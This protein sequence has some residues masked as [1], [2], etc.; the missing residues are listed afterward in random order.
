MTVKKRVLYIEDDDDSR[1]LVVKV[2]GSNGYEV[3]AAADGLEG[4]ALAKSERPQLVLM[5]INLPNLDGRII[6]TRLRSLPDLQDVPIV[7]LTANNSPGSR[8]RALAAGCTGFLTKPIDV[9]ELPTQVASFL[10]GQKQT[11]SPGL[12]NT[13]LEKHAQDVV[14]QL[15]AKVRELEAMNERLYRL[16]RLKSD[17]ITLASHEL[18]T[19]L[20]LVS[21]Y[22]Q[23][24]EQQLAQLQTAV[25]SP[26]ASVDKPFHTAQKLNHGVARLAQV[27]EE[28]IGVSRIAT[29]RLDLYFVPVQLGQVVADI[30]ADLAAVFQKRAIEV[31]VTGL[32]ALPTIRGD[33]DHIKTAVANVIENAI[34]FTPDGGQIFIKGLDQ[35]DAVILSVSDTGIG[36]PKPEQACIF[37]QFYI[38]DSINNHSSSKHAFMGGGMGLGLALTRGIMNAHN[39]R[40]W[41]ES[42]KRDPETLPGSTFYLLFPLS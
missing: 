14:A 2:L 38:I 1:R 7:A 22:A 21:G 39:G 11:L 5:D 30:L 27:V 28:V 4:V 15:E 12:L 35:K 42:E 17:F 19:P 18:R 23:L 8:E 26:P 6:T 3:L 32:D 34:K 16:D 9:D 25:S 29:N 33:A 31:Q 24:L 20:T 36:I 10:N 40:V 13:H 37:D 41:V